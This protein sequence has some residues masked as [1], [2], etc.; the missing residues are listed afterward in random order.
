MKF[1]LDYYAMLRKTVIKFEKLK[2]MYAGHI[3][4][5]DKNG[6]LRLGHI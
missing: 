5:V 6:F 3:L 4:R 1:V 2:I